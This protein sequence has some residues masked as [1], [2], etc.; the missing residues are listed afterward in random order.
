MLL[1]ILLV[2]NIPIYLLIAWLIFDSRSN[3]ADT[4]FDTIVSLLKAIFIP[5]IVRIFMDDDDGGADTLML[6]VFLF[7]CG[8]IVY[9]E[10]FLIEKYFLS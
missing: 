5:R 6:V 8:I 2:L 1:T 7:L 10:Y 3:A 9:G 4:I